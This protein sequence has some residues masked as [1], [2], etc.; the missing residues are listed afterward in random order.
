[1][2]PFYLIAA[3]AAFFSAPGAAVLRRRD[4]TGSVANE[5]S[6]ITLSPAALPLC[7]SDLPQPFYPLLY[8]ANVTTPPLPPLPGRSKINR[9]DAADERRPRRLG[10]TDYFDY[11]YG[12]ADPHRPS[13]VVFNQHS[14]GGSLSGLSS[15]ASW[16]FYTVD[17]KNP[18]WILEWGHLAGG[19]G[20]DR[21]LEC[22]VPCRLTHDRSWGENGKADIVVFGP[23]QQKGI[24]VFGP[25]Q[26][27]AAEALQKSGKKKPHQYYAVTSLESDINF[28]YLKDKNTL[29]HFDLKATYHLDSDVPRIYFGYRGYDWMLPPRAK[30]KDRLVSFVSSSCSPRNGRTRYVMSLSQYVPV[31][32]FGSCL[33]NAS[34]ADILETPIEN[35]RWH[36]K[37]VILQHF[38]FNIAFENSDTPDYITEKFGQALVAGTVPIVKSRTNNYEAFAP[39]PHS[40][41]VADD[42]ES[43]KALAEYLLWLNDHDEEYDKYLEWKRVGPSESFR[44][45]LE[46]NIPDSSCHLCRFAALARDVDAGYVNTD[47]SRPAA[48]IAET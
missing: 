2:L 26:Q 44:R 48:Q 46:L 8:S 14:S 19:L 4:H 15:P 42:F 16:Q 47:A 10:W 1:M 7:P 28:A 17:E 34:F 25:Q 41:I 22:D 35:N 6:A 30:R 40:Y 11:R 9:M 32:S 5:G 33:R 39:H 27:K 45:L 21:R 37:V 29:M 13:G 3:F 38:K 43:P 12:C 20:G 23:Q 36:E 24:V 18:V 31:R